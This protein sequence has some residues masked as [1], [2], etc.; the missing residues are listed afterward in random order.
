MNQEDF[1]KLFR[2][3][4]STLVASLLLAS[5]AIAAPGHRAKAKPVSCPVCH[6]ALS[7]K[8]DKSHTV[9]VK[10]KGKTMYCCAGCSMP[11]A[12]HKTK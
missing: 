10:I 7:K 8:K 3:V 4:I 2:P 5:V 12:E 6:M 1:V 9:A 11:K